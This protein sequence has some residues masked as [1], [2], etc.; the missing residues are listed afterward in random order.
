MEEIISRHGVPT[1]LLSHWGISFHSL[2]NLT[3]EV[4]QLMGVHK[5]NTTAYHT[6]T[7]GLVERFNRTLTDMLAKTVERNGYDWDHHL[8]FVLFAY[9]SSLQESTQESL[10][11]L[12]YGR[13]PRLLTETAC[14]QSTSDMLP[15][16]FRGLQDPSDNKPQRGMRVGKKECSEG[17]EA[18]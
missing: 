11:F 17:P 16:R 10:F 18:A 13:D 7:D 6:Q 8:P 1:E 2:P 9:R 15:N 5:L 3:Q 14:P 4:N 12:L